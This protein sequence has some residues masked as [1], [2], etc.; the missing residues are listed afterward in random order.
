MANDFFRDGRAKPK[1]EI[2]R[3]LQVVSRTVV[4]RI[5]LLK[6]K[7]N[8]SHLK[9]GLTKKLAGKF[10]PNQVL[11]DVSKLTKTPNAFS[12]FGY[13]FLCKS[14]YRLSRK[15]G[16]SES[17]MFEPKTESYDSCLKG[18]KGEGRQDQRRCRSRSSSVRAETHWKKATYYGHETSEDCK[19][20][21]RC[22]A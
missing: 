4:F 3:L 21:S 17:D 11:S 19:D 13:L 9:Y 16:V 15:D 7:E 1:P 2:M 12:F 8:S 10:E 6:M 14:L 18:I 22:R 20:Q 5:C